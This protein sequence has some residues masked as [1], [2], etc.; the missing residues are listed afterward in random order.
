MVK[1]GESAVITPPALQAE[2]KPALPSN[3]LVSHGQV[4]LGFRAMVL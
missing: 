3:N 2:D 4:S 1:A